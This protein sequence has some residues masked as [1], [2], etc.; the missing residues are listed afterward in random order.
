[1]S[2]APPLV[3]LDSEMVASTGVTSVKHGITLTSINE[4]HFK[5]LYLLEN[6]G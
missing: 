5:V 6:S 2:F 1:M 4:Y 3:S